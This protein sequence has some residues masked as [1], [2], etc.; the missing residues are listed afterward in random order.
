MVKIIEEKGHGCGYLMLLEECSQQSFV[1]GQSDG[2]QRNKK[3]I[4][5]SLIRVLDM[6]HSKLLR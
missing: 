5:N 6:E 3:P 1:R 2:V 4:L